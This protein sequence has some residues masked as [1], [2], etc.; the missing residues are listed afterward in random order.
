MSTLGKRLIGAAKEARVMT[1]QNGD[2][3]YAEFERALTDVLTEREYVL[4][5]RTRLARA[6]AVVDKNDP[7]YLEAV[8]SAFSVLDP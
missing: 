2:E 4:E 7:Q 3:R 8:E 5:P 6:R 1:Q